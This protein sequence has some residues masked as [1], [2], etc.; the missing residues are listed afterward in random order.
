MYVYY[1]SNISERW[2]EIDTQLL[3]YISMDRQVKVLRY[4]HISDKK[5]SLYAELVTRLGIS[6]MTG[7]PA[8]ELQFYSEPNH[9]P[10]LLNFPGTDFSFSHS[11]NCILCCI[12]SDT[13][14]GADVERV[15]S[16][17]LEVIYQVFHPQEIEYIKAAP[18][19][20]INLRFFEIWTRKEAYTKYLGTGLVSDLIACNT[21]DFSSY[22]YTWQEGDCCCSICGT[23]LEPVKITHLSEKEIQDYFTNSID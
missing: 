15:T 20:Q 22:L 18:T 8:S 10:Y 5:L 16:A 19:G 21:L 1:L 3:K 6:Q 17:P 14:V 11:S 2:S 7:C 12:S 9:K 13:A 4:L 23:T